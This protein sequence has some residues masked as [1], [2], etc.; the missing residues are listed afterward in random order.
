[1]VAVLDPVK[2]KEW[3]AENFKDVNIETE[4]LEDDQYMG[5][6]ELKK[7]VIEDMKRLADMNKLTGL[8]RIKDPKWLTMT[9]KPF[10]ME[11]DLIT[12]TQKLKR[13]KA[14]EIYATE[15]AKMYGKH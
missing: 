10:T 3:A 1:M 8:E 5:S 9:L 13:N 11:N 2:V 7:L 12:P 4:N 14:K 6:L 15:I